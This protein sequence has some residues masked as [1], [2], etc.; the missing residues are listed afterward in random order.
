MAAIAYARTKTM[1]TTHKIPRPVRSHLRY[2]FSE[3]LKMYLLVLILLVA[4]KSLLLA[5]RLKVEQ[6]LIVSGVFQAS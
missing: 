2:Y 6:T 4:I 3:T 1:L 5:L